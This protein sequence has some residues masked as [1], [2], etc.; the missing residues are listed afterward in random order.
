MTYFDSASSLEKDFDDRTND[1][2]FLIALQLQNQFDREENENEN[3]NEKQLDKITKIHPMN[4][5]DKE[6]ELIDPNPE[7]HILFQ[8]FNHQFFYRKLDSVYV[9]WSKRMTRCAGICYY[10][11]GGECRIALSASYLTLRPRKDLVE[12]LLHEMIHAYLFVTHNTRD[13]DGHGLEFLKHMVR[14]ND[15]T[16]ANITVYH[17]FHDEYDH[18]HGHWWRCTGSCRQWKPFYGYVKRSMNRVPS[19]KDRWWDEHERRCGGKFEKIK[20]PENY[21]AKENRKRTTNE[22]TSNKKNQDESQPSTSQI[23]S[24]LKKKKKTIG[25]VKPNPGTIERFFKK[26]NSTSSLIDMKQ[27]EQNKTIDT[28]SQETPS[29]IKSNAN[30]EN[31]QNYVKCPI[32]QTFLPK[33]N[34]FIHQIRCHK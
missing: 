4:V 24:P 17:S 15:A 26:A 18:L 6:W 3:E 16:G 33:A 23:S 7:I 13:R 28:N 12:T 21:K 10:R 30:D 14:I 34:L 1:E 20:E 5:V 19:N 11:R 27:S 8:Q 9:E 32:C 25:D 22:I 29:A 2:D 31:K